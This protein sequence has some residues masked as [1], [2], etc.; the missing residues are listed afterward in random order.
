MSGPLTADQGTAIINSFRSVH[1]FQPF[2]A[3]SV[4][5]ISEHLVLQLDRG[6]MESIVEYMVTKH[7]SDRRT[8]FLANLTAKMRVRPKPEPEALAAKPAPEPAPEPEPEVFGEK[9]PKYVARVRFNLLNG[10]R[11]EETRAVDSLSELDHLL[12]RGPY[13]DSI[14]NIKIKLEIQP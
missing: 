1:Q 8:E 7:L 3:F 6:A 4:I 11:L 9:P 2:D 5:Y 14:K 10:R 12:D 13:D